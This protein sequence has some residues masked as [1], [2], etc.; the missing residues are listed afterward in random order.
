MSQKLIEKNIEHQRMLGL[1]SDVDDLIERVK[2]LEAARPPPKDRLLSQEES[3]VVIGV[4]P[5]TLAAW[6]HYG[7]GPRYIKVGRSA[8]YKM[9][10]IENW[11]DQQAVV[12]AEG[13]AA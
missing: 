4:K 7:K 9:E 6:R 3:A 12:P 1:A 8:F 11:L 13:D 5:P 2:R 10:D